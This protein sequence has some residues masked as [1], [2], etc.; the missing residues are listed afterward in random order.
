MTTPTQQ[1]A[2]TTQAASHDAV[3]QSTF[4]RVPG[5]FKLQF[6]PSVT[7]ISV[8]IMVFVG[9]WFL[10]AGIGAWIHHTAGTRVAAEDPIY[11]G[12]SQAALWCLV[13]MA[14]YAAS[15]TFP[16]SMAL[17]Y[18]RRTFMLGVLLAFG[19]VSL[20]FGT[21]FSLAALVERLSDGFGIHFYT[22]DLPYITQGDG[23]IVA[24]GALAAIVCLVLMLFGFFWAILYRRAGL[25]GL[26]I[27]ILGFAVVGLVATMLIF[28]NDGWPV[29]WE[30]LIEQ[31]ALSLTGWLV[32]PTALLALLNYGVIRRATPA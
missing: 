13:F 7:L 11:T 23:G 12:A 31:S 28:Q 20:S 24:G 25:L 3:R 26:W 19:L 32:I 16:F 10:A 6:S 14:A 17:S 2:H 8:P 9:V 15:H 18:S 1:S 22:Y 27:V 29:I 5:A 4:A 21:A 30:W